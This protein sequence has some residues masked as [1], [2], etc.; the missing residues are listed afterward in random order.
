MKIKNTNVIL[1]VDI[2]DIV[3]A[4]KIIF[5]LK[6]YIL[7]V[8][9]HSDIIDGIHEYIPTLKKLATLHNFLI[10]DDRKFCDIGFTV[11]KQSSFITEYADLITVHTIPGKSILEGLENNCIKN[12][13]GILLI[14]QMSTESLIT[15][16]YTEKTIEMAKDY[17][18]IVVGF[19]CQEFMC[20]GFY[21]FTPGVR[22]GQS[23]DDMSQCYNTPD[24]LI[25]KKK[26]DI[27]IVGRGIYLA[28]DPVSKIKNYICFK[29]NCFDSIIK[30]GLVKTGEFKLK[31]GEISNIYFDLRNIINYPKLMNKICDEMTEYVN[32]KDNT[33]ILGIPTGGIPFATLISQK[34]NI[35]MT[36]VKKEQKDYGLN[37]SSDF[38]GKSVV[39]IEDTVTTGNSVL[40]IINNIK[41]YDDVTVITILD[42]S[43]NSMKNISDLGH[44]THSLYT[45][46]EVKNKLIN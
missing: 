30:K 1:S 15:K 40:E 23:S 44:N 20:D 36:I 24:Y 9:I 38:S 13:C 10:I 21:H 29:K 12:N 2:C 42:R 18:N 14:S 3:K 31:S 35:P 27:L 16:E 37:Q 17:S 5:D 46:N 19:I 34:L 43:D 45:L 7:G 28:E 41:N 11:D 25:N 4:K 8:K 26:T 39:I 6:E 22:L 32:R 33:V